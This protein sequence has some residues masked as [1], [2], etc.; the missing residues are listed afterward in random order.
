MQL[1]NATPLPAPAASRPRPAPRFAVKPKTLVTGALAFTVTLLCIGNIEPSPYDFGLLLLAP[2]ALIEGL[3]INRMTILMFFVIWALLSSEIV[4][5]MPYLSHRIIDQGETPSV[6]EIYSAF[7]YLTMFLFLFVFSRDTGARVALALKA[8]AI[9]C[10]VASLIGLAQYAEIFGVSEQISKVGRA[11]GPFNDPNVLGSFC[12]LGIAYLFQSLL[13][14][15]RW[16]LVKLA[17]LIIVIVGGEFVTY[18]RGSWAASAFCMAFVAVMT[19]FTSRVPGVRLRVVSAIAGGLILAA[20]G[21]VYIESNASLSQMLQDR[22]KV[23]QDYDS[24]EDGR[25]GHQRR[26]IPMLLERPFGFGPFRFPLYF[27]LQPHNSYLTAFTDSGWTGGISFL[28]FVGATLTFATRTAFQRSSIMPQAQALTPAMYA[29]YGQALQIDEGHWR[30]LYVIVAAIWA[31]E[32][33]RRGERRGTKAASPQQPLMAAPTFVAPIRAKPRLTGWG[34]TRLPT[35]TYA[36]PQSALDAA[37]A[38]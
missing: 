20:A 32:G 27:E 25:F 26:A 28:F 16:F 34:V 12:V 30:F 10:V 1:V 5:L 9:G 36:A 24:G 7:V 35:P 2:A 29:I 37:Q 38:G 3:R 8:Y 17:S 13:V 19:F 18:S 11:T 4:A 33:V 6:Y 23:S 14:S 22:L 31:L 15:R 21:V